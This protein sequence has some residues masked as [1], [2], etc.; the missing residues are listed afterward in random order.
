MH[1][2]IQTVS[3]DVRVIGSLSFLQPEWVLN[4]IP[5][6]DRL[7]YT[8]VTNL[9][10]YS[11]CYQICNRHCAR[12]SYC[13]HY[14]KLPAN[15]LYLCIHL[16][17]QRQ[18]EFYVLGCLQNQ[19]EELNS[20]TCWSVNTYHASFKLISDNA[21]RLSENR[22]SC[23]GINTKANNVAT[24]RAG[25]EWVNNFRAQPECFDV[26]LWNLVFLRGIPTSQTLCLP[27]FESF[28]SWNIT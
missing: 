14:S 10:R 28:C 19:L 9:L 4:L 25:D 15:Y 11:V 21:L 12:V 23:R 17:L 1:E 26:G 16:L 13:D 24:V 6:S 7:R 18:M 8:L 22:S 2:C 3:Q 20:D 27:C 5:A